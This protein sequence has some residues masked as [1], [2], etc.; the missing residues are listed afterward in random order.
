MAEIKTKWFDFS[1]NNSGGSFRFDEKR[2]IT[3]YVVIEAID[4]KHAN[5][6]AEEIGLYFDGC[7]SGMDCDCCGDRW[8]A[9]WKSD[10][11]EEEPSVYGEPIRSEG[12]YKC[13]WIKHIG[14][15]YAVHPINGPIEWYGPTE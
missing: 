2:G 10:D 6:R 7:S 1:Q 5:M 14:K 12:P 11:G 4:Y 8:S 3:A 9:A 15:E 13:V